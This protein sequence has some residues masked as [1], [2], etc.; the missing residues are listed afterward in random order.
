[1]EIINETGLTEQDRILKTEL[2]IA[3]F[4]A[5]LYR[6]RSEVIGQHVRSTSAI[7]D[8]FELIDVYIDDENP[9]TIS[10]KELVASLPANEKAIRRAVSDVKKWSEEWY[11]ANPEVVSRIVF[12]K[13]CRVELHAK[14]SWDE[15]VLPSSLLTNYELAN[16]KL[17]DPK[18]YLKAIDLAA[19]NPRNCIVEWLSL[20]LSPNF[21]AKLES[22]VIEVFANLIRKRSQDNIC[23]AANNYFQREKVFL[24]EHLSTPIDTSWRHVLLDYP[25]RVNRILFTDSKSLG[26]A[27][28]DWNSICSAFKTYLRRG[29]QVAIVNQD[30]FPVFKQFPGANF[31]IDECFDL[32]IPNDEVAFLHVFDSADPIRLQEISDAARNLWNS[33]KIIQLESGKDWSPDTLWSNLYEQTQA[34]STH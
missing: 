22:S 17:H 27:K 19:R 26:Q 1:M 9:Q 30:D 28:P 4:R 34:K 21:L 16:S 10:I 14:Q 18:V 20:M 13:D 15:E 12:T 2:M 8:K 33:D 6:I 29:E 11:Q 24:I 32:R 31:L 7:L 23:R 5:S 25:S 3:D